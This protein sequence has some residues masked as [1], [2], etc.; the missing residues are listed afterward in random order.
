MKLVHVEK[1]PYPGEQFR[2]TH[3][4]VEVTPADVGLPEPTNAVE[5][6]AAMLRMAYFAKWTCL[7]QAVMDGCLSRAEFDVLMT[8]YQGN[9]N[10]GTTGSQSNGAVPAEGRTS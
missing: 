10:A 7:F 8:P 6:H 1:F 2:S 4:Q 3:W 9:S 5:A